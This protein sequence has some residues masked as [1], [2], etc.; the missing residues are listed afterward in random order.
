MVQILAQILIE[1]DYGGRVR[2]SM[3]AH[4]AGAHATKKE[5]AVVNTF[6]EAMK[7]TMVLAADIHGP[8]Q[9]R[10]QQKSVLALTNG[11]KP[12]RKL[13]KNRK[14]VRQCQLN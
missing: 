3:E 4:H 9:N 10:P 1:Q 2:S 11:S 5:L 8:R 6:I 7:A 13:I 12:K 14:R